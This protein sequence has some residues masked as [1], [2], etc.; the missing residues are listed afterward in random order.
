MSKRLQ[1]NSY[2]SPAA[3]QYRGTGFEYGGAAGSFRFG[4][5]TSTLQNVSI[6]VFQSKNVRFKSDC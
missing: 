6:F 2:G 3:K 5:T 4:P 1:G